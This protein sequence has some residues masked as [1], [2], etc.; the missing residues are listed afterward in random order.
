MLNSFIVML[1]LF[2][3]QRIPLRLYWYTPIAKVYHYL[4]KKEEPSRNDIYFIGVFYSH[5]EIMMSRQICIHVAVMCVFQTIIRI[6]IE[7]YR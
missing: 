5:L 2:Y 4:S 7:L 3:P 1:C 6:D